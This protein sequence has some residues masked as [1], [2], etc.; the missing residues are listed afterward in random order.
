MNVYES[1]NSLAGYGL[2]T[3][4]IKKEDV[5]YTKNRLLELF[6]LDGFENERQAEF[7][8]SVEVCELENILKSLLDYAV[9]KNFIEDSI[10][11][12]DLFDTKIMSCLVAR[13]SEVQAEFSSLYKKS[14]KEATD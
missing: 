8:P 14:A 1:I 10:V 2:A 12:R 13:P 5:V 7:V 4:L 3:G 6:A 9:E 11:Y